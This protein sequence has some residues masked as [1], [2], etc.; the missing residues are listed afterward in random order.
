MTRILEVSGAAAGG[1]RT[2]L[3]DC[4]TLLTE[5][6]H[7]VT[8]AAPAAVLAD[9]GRT[10]GPDGNDG[11]DGTDG[12]HRTGHAHTCVLPI[13]SRP[14]VHDPSLVRTLRHLVR[15]VD[16]VHA[17][18]LRAGALVALALGPRADPTAGGPRMVVTEHNLT[19]GSAPVRGLGLL[20]ERIVARRADLVL[21]VSPDLV[22]RARAVGARATRLAVV[23]APPPARVPGSAEVATLRD[24]LLAVSA[25]VESPLLV[26]TVA[27]LAPQKGLDLLL[28][29]AGLLAARVRAGEL[30]A[31]TWLVAGEGPGRPGAEQR[32]TA[33]DLPVRLLGRRGDVATL[34]AACDLVVQT[35]LWEGQPLTVQEALRAGAP[36]V[37]TDVGGTALTARGGARLVAA[38][39]AAL[40]GAVGAM[41]ADPD[42]RRRAAQD[43]RAAAQTLP[44]R[45]D[46]AAQLAEVLRPA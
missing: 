33:E 45:A 20:L 38:Q 43:A 40:A 25:P 1:V 7:H 32:V 34:M 21:G 12:S 17:H 8:V 42:R 44:T 19:V 14:S 3:H 11:N 30:P 36:L 37:A 16:V 2:H 6:G 28:D 26:L 4:A 23:P 18:G 41:L 24:H 9:A 35:S 13:G 39:A 46:L 5:D 29:A 10:G 22:A 27:R 31:F 15:D